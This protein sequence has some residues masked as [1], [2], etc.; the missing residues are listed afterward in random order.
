MSAATVKK[1]IDMAI[2]SGDRRLGLIF[3]G[4]EPLLCR[5]LIE[6][7]VEYSSEKARASG[8]ERFFYKI[9]TNGLLLDDAFLQYARKNDIFIA[10]S[11]DGIEKAHDAHRRDKGGGPTHSMA[12]AAAERLLRIFP[13]SPALMTVNPDTVKHYAES[14]EYL[15]SL[16]FRYLVCSLNFAAE[17]DGPALRELKRQY[18]RLASFYYAHT[19]AEDKFYMSPFDVK[20]SSH[21]H[22]RTYCHERCELGQRQLSVAPDG[23]IYPCVQFAGDAEYRIGDVYGGLDETARQA[24]YTRNETEKP[25]C[26]ACSIQKRCNHYCACL[27]KQA[28]GSIDAVSSVLCA[29]ERIILPIADRVAARLYKKRSPMFIQKHYNDLYP[30]V[31]LAEDRAAGRP[32]GSEP[33][34]G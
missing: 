1:T 26:D 25:G 15:Y 21:I 11:I 19:L 20:I 31:S 13:Y 30:L 12:V 27:N 10:L 17:W 16:G 3:F 2:Q 4:G 22:N 7:A 33:E 28:T 9:T 6:E 29:H 18:K 24:L 14:A 8:R 5:G 34:G 23:G 32:E